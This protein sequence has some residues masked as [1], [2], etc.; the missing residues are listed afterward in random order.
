MNFD[1]KNTKIPQIYVY[2]YEYFQ[3]TTFTCSSIDKEG[4][5]PTVHCF[6]QKYIQ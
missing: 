6:R 2:I 1:R 3:C 4:V 5:T